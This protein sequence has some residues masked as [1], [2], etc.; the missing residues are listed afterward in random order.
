MGYDEI[1][2]AVWVEKMTKGWNPGIS[3]FGQR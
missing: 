1:I 3:M 2:K